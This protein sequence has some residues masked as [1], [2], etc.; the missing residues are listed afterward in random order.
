M[1]P[2]FDYF[3]LKYPTIWQQSEQQIVNDLLSANPD[4]KLIALKK[5]ATIFRIKFQA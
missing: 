5:G 4:T 3:A 1:N 2:T